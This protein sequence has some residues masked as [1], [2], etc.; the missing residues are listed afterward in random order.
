MHT[1]IH[2]EADN[3][4]VCLP[5]FMDTEGG[6]PFEV[7]AA[8]LLS[9]GLHSNRL[10]TTDAVLKVLV[11][12]LA[13]LA[14]VVKN[15]T[16]VG[17]MYTVDKLSLHEVCSHFKYLYFCFGFQ[18]GFDFLV[19]GVSAKGWTINRHFNHDF[20]FWDFSQSLK[21]YNRRKIMNL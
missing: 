16:Y 5:L 13:K 17:C 11:F 21:R 9:T 19:G 18:V 4:C 14:S 6:L 7:S 12:F 8:C 15:T 1:N 10:N 20:D 3:V 2:I